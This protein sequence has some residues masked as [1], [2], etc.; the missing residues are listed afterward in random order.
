MNTIRCRLISTP[1]GTMLAGAS[2]RAIGWLEFVEDGEADVSRARMEKKFRQQAVDGT[3]ALLNTL[4]QE[5]ARYF[6]GALKRWSLPMDRRG[7]EFQQ[8]V[9]SALEE[10]PFGETRSYADIA[11]AVGRPKAVRAIGRANG[12]NGIYLLVPC[13]RVIAS[14]GSISGYGGAVWRKEWLLDME[15][16]AAGK[17]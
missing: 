17:P 7:T 9:W 5:L 14:D 6:R 16:R 11:R 3:S 4:E 12:S 2:D 15:K 10:I 8:R 1:I 13:H